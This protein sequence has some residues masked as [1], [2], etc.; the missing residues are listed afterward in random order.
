L[1]RNKDRLGGG[2]SHPHN[3]PTPPQQVNSPGTS[4]GFSFVV[5]TEFVELPSKG[6][7]YSPDHPLYNQ[8]TVEVKQMTAKEEDMLTSRSLLKKGVAL[9]RVLQSVIVD[10]NINPD[11]LLIGDR[12][13][14]IVA[15]RVSGYGSD[16]NTSVTC[17][18]CSD[19][20]KYDFNLN[21]ITI[22]H[23]EDEI[24]TGVVPLENGMF[25][26]V[27]PQSE[28]HVVFRLL[29][30]HDEKRMSKRVENARKRNQQEKLVTSQL[31][32]ILVSVNGDASSEALQYVIE[33]M[34]S[35]DARHL[36][37][38]YKLSAP[39]LD[40]TQ[41]FNCSSC[42]HEQELEVPLTADFFWPDR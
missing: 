15:M 16:Y 23:G 11:T 17:P 32:N 5:P 40:M 19:A 3:A 28:L 6:K 8:E 7:F 25:G 39:N 38:M 20:Q 18:A 14:L 27:L 24:E 12:N 30:G 21:D 42:G 35:G 2:F 9:D 31:R 1:S 29:N 4:G 33:N 26:T 36:R 37:L 13:A 22:F 10:K 41:H 34:P